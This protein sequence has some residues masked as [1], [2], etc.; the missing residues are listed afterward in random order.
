MK[1]RDVNYLCKQQILFR[2]QHVFVSSGHVLR[3]EFSQL[4]SGCWCVLRAW[5]TNRCSKYFPCNLILHTHFYHQVPP[6]RRVFICRLHCLTGLL[7]FY[8]TFSLF[9]FARCCALLLRNT[10][11]LRGLCGVQVCV[12]ARCVLTV[13]TRLIM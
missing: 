10:T 5:K 9:L 3:I 7:I 11:G 12:C 2:K 6:L 4:P 13:R 1:Q 8:S